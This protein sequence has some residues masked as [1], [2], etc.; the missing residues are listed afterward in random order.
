MDGFLDVVQSIIITLLVTETKT[1]GKQVTFQGSW[2]VIIRTGD[3]KLLDFCFS[4]KRTGWQSG[5][6]RSSVCDST[7]PELATEAAVPK[8]CSQ[9]LLDVGPCGHVTLPKLGIQ[10]AT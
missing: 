10:E 2:L 4:R 8:T 3:E 6:P 5:C 1:Q 7:T 9:M